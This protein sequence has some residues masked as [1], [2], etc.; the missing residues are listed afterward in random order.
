MLWRMQLHFYSICSLK[1]FIL[2]HNLRLLHNCRKETVKWNYRWKSMTWWEKKI[3]MLIFSNSEKS[4]HKKT[5][6]IIHKYIF[7]IIL[8]CIFKNIV[9]KYIKYFILLNI[10]YISIL[11][12][13]CILHMLNS[14][15]IMFS[16]FYVGILTLKCRLILN[17]LKWLCLLNT[18][19]LHI[20]Y[21]SLCI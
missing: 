7:L 21:G 20:F 9:R 11:I 4:S 10:C 15:W 2:T 12:Y 19:I 8:K 13:I 3:I 17:E 5:L 6:Y 14:Y 1:F 16:T 18:I